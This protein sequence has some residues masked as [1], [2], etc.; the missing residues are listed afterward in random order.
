M[1]LTQSNTFWSVLVIVSAVGLFVSIVI[2]ITAIVTEENAGEPI[3]P[4]IYNLQYDMMNKVARKLGVKSLPLKGVNNHRANQNVTF[5]FELAFATR[6]RT[7]DHLAS[8][9]EVADLLFAGFYPSMTEYCYAMQRCQGE[10]FE[11]SFLDSLEVY[12]R[13]LDEI[14][15]DIPVFIGIGQ[16]DAR[17]MRLL[18]ST[19]RKNL[20][21]VTPYILESDEITGQV[22]GFTYTTLSTALP[23]MNNCGNRC[24]K[25]L[26]KE[27]LSISAELARKEEGEEEEEEYDN[28]PVSLAEHL[29][30]TL[31]KLVY[32]TGE[33]KKLRVMIAT[34]DL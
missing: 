12:G 22:D 26:L 32:T 2:G 16:S 21:F 24:V 1:E 17:L 23:D 14:D 27:N 3:R 4:F 6:I 9:P 20:I 8:S 29:G 5:N 11:A 10:G 33:R 31:Y 19:W 34:D 28:D 30:D 18:V 15:K 7:S 25:R 13:Q